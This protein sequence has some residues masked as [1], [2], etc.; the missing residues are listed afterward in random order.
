MRVSGR[1]I[2]LIDKLNTWTGRITAPLMIF[3][4]LSVLVEIISRGAFN[5][6]TIWASETTQFFYILCSFLA[7]GYIL[8][9][10]G[11]IAVDVFYA[12]MSPRTQLLVDLITFPFFML[13]VGSMLWFGT[14]FA[15]ESLL[16]LERTGSVWD[17]P[18]Y[19]IKFVV[20][21]GAGLVLVQGIANL[22]RKFIDV[23]ADHQA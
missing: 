3:I 23:M 21:I 8:K 2:A 6:P 19:P 5:N 4:C 17:P 15:V 10:R 11:H 22:A 1:T 12:R 16:K 18:I 13:F 7:G 9:D 14:D 20:P